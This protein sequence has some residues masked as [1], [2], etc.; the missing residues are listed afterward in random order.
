LKHLYI[1][2]YQKIELPE[3]IS[4]SIWIHETKGAINKFFK[5]YNKTAII[6]LKGAVCKDVILLFHNNRALDINLAFILD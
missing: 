6:E 3:N 2:R 4:D 5:T 1:D